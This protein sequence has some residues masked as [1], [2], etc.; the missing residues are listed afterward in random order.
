MYAAVIVL[1]IVAGLGNQALANW[2][3]TQANSSNGW[4]ADIFRPLS[5]TGWRF[6]AENGQTTAEWLAPLL[7]NIVLLILTFFFV[8]ISARDAGHVSLFFGTWGAATLAGGIAG[9]VATPLAYQNIG[10]PASANFA[11]M[12]GDGLVLGFL[13]GFVAAIVAALFAGPSAARAANPS[14]PN[15]GGIM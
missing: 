14:A 7:F 2:R 3:E 10:T 9:L 15:S 13:V 1:L 8:D 12:L 6:S 4:I 5:L 11:M